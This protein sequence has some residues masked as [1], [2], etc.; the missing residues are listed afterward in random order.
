MCIRDRSWQTLKEPTMEAEKHMAVKHMVTEVVTEE[1][2]AEVPA[3]EE[4]EEDSEAEPVGVSAEVDSVVEIV[5]EAEDISKQTML[6]MQ[7][8]KVSGMKS[9]GMTQIP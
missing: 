5:A 4:I 8:V 3:A 2:R 6:R 9:H 7:V 1:A